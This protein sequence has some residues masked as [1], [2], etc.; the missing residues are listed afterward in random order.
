MYR[1]KNLPHKYFS[2]TIQYGA[3]CKV[4]VL[5]QGFFLLSCNGGSSHYLGR[6]IKAQ[7]ITG[8]WTDYPQQSAHNCPKE[9][10]AET[11]WRRLSAGFDTRLK[12]NPTRLT[13]WS[14]V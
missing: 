4:L 3:K 5:S 7:N 11:V 10:A 13:Y 1:I 8:F 6:P 9:E 2:I 14:N 12:A